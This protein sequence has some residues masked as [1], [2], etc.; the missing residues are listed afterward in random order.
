MATDP[1]T[2]SQISV[3]KD[4]WYIIWGKKIVLP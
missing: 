2:S 1:G 4:E 3:Q